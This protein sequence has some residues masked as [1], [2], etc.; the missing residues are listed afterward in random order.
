MQ[1]QRS[2]QDLNS[3]LQQHLNSIART[4]DNNTLV[5]ENLNE[6]D[7]IEFDDV[8]EKKEECNF[9]DSGRNTTNQTI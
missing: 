4:Q 1:H 7:D 9:E 6:Y 3:Q 5:K 2:R 8:P